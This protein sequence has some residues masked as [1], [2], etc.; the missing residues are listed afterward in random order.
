[1]TT[2]AYL[3]LGSNLGDKK[4]NIA[5]AIKHIGE[6]A[7]RVVE[8][9]DL[10]ETAPCGFVSANDFINAAICV[11]TCLT[12]RQ[13]LAATQQIE[14]MMGRTEKS[15]DG[16]YHDRVIDIDILLY[17]TE[18][19]DEPDLKIPHPEM[20]KR[21]FVMRPLLDVTRRETFNAYADEYLEYM[22]KMPDEK[23]GRKRWE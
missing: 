4:R 3:A 9:S 11:E 14:R 16:V 21:S 8:Q 5:E 22:E 20:W 6:L 13:L 7:G 18:T 2:T 19:I 17:G 23:I 10:Y 1:M 12:P 15:S